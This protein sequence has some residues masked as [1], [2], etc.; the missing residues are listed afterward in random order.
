MHKQYSYDCMGNNNIQIKIFFFYF[1]VIGIT[2]RVICRPLIDK[3]T[4]RNQVLSAER[5]DI[6]GYDPAILLR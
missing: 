3:A 2:K 1:F 5:D 6:I 4:E